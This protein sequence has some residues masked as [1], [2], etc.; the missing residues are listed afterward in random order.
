MLRQLVLA[1]LFEDCAIQKRSR[2]PHHGS[3]VAVFCRESHLENNERNQILTRHDAGN[4]PGRVGLPGATDNAVTSRREW[5][6]RLF[7]DM[8]KQAGRWHGTRLPEASC[9]L[10][11]GETA[12]PPAARHG[13]RKE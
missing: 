4:V 9:A 1:V 6:W 10:G 12:A 3:R 11:A 2:E 8:R 5:P 13:A 7:Q